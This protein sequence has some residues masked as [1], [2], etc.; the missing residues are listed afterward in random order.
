MIA[1]VVVAVLGGFII[2]FTHLFASRMLCKMIE[3]TVMC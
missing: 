3:M 1:F 2:F